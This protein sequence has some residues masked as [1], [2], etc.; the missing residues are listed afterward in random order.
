MENKTRIKKLG[1]AYDLL[2]DCGEVY[3]KSQ[4]EEMMIKEGYKVVVSRDKYKF[5]WVGLNDII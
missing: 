3:L 2:S 5:K 1:Q 4:L